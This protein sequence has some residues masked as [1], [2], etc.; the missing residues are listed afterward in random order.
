MEV[1]IKDTDV[2]SIDGDIPQ[3]NA[4]K[5]SSDMHDEQKIVFNKHNAVASAVEQANDRSP[6]FRAFKTE[7]PKHTVQNLPPE[8]FPMKKRITKA[9]K[10]DD[11]CGLNLAPTTRCIDRFY[12]SF[13]CRCQQSDHSGEL[14]EWLHQEWC[15]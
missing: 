7:L 4:M 15:H 11:L 12:C 13:A 8:R 9:F 3:L 1:D 5:N 6:I 10:S 14:Q 2:M